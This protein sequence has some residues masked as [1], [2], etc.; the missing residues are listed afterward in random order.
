MFEGFDITT[1][2]IY[3]LLN[4]FIKDT[5]EIGGSGTDIGDLIGGLLK[6]F[7]GGMFGGKK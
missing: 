7:L 1:I 5:P 4:K 2:I 3:I 6:K